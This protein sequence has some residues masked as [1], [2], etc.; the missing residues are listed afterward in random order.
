MELTEEGRHGARQDLWLGAGI[1]IDEPLGYQGQ[2][3]PGNLSGAAG[4]RQE[5]RHFSV[6]PGT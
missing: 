5:D 1:K 6:E 4:Q 2:Q 3:F